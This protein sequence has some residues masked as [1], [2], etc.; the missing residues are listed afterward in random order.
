[1]VLAFWDCRQL[2]AKATAPHNGASSP[3]SAG[4]MSNRTSG[5]AVAIAGSMGLASI[6]GRIVGGLLMDR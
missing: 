2:K 1:M 3:S 4:T 5:S 6:I